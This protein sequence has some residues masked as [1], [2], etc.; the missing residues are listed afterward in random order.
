M[1]T[2]KRILSALALS[3]FLMSG[4]GGPEPEPVPGPTPVTPAKIS[5]TGVSLNKSSITLVEGANESLVATVSPS[6]ATDKEV[7]WSSSESS[8]ASVDSKGTVKA[9]KAGTTTVTV[10]TNDG[11]K[12]ASCSVTVE[13]KVISVT[14]VS[15]DQN[16]LE[17]IEG[18][19]AT[20]AS[21]VEPGD[22]TNKTVAW[23]SSDPTVAT[24]EDGKVVA[25]APG[26]A[27]ITVT[28]EDGK[29]TDS[30]EVTIKSKVIHLERLKMDCESLTLRAHWS[31]PIVVSFFPDNAEDQTVN[32]IS[33]D[34]S[35]AW[36]K[37]RPGQPYVCDVQAVSP[38][39]ASIIA[40]SNDGGKTA[41][42]NVTVTPIP[43]ERV[44]IS[45]SSML[46]YVG[47][48]IQW[49]VY[50]AP[51]EATNKNVTWKVADP[52][53]ASV[54]QNGVIKG[55][56]P[57]NTKVS[58]VSEDG[59][60]TSEHELWVREATVK[61]TSIELDK[62]T[63]SMTSGTDETLTA[64]L[65]PSDATNKDVIWFSSDLNV[66]WVSKDGIVS[67]K[68]PGTCTVTAISVDG[69]FESTCVVTVGASPSSKVSGVRMSNSEIALNVGGIAT[70]YATVSP[71]TATNKGLTWTSSDPS[72]AKVDNYGNV[73]AVKVGSAVITVKTAD[74]GYT[75]KCTV[76][77]QTQVV[78]AQK[79]TLD[80]TS[81]TLNVKSQ[82]RLRATISPSGVTNPNL[83]WESDNTSVA[84]V[85]DSGV[86]TAVGPGQTRIIVY[87]VDNGAAAICVVA[88]RKFVDSISISGPKSVSVFSSIHLEA[89]VSPANASNR[90]V[91]WSSSNTAI[92]TVDQ[93]GN[94]KGIKE[95][96]V[97]ISVASKDGSGAIATIQVTVTSAA[98]TYLMLA[99]SGAEVVNR[100][101]MIVGEYLSFGV[102]PYPGEHKPEVTW[103]CS[104]DDIIEIRDYMDKQ[105][106]RLLYAKKA[107]TCT[108]TL[109]AQDSGG[110]TRTFTVV[111]KQQ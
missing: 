90:N 98:T 77:V 49:D 29:K 53:I 107:G 57:G 6:D 92:A 59:G 17:L 95:G 99:D 55:L 79:V 84:R 25:V 48:E 33:T 26:T 31:E 2:I 64:I 54:D 40:V 22:A 32:W 67:A 7:S 21:T 14:S 63:L 28:T 96:E 39:E 52:S 9:V 86:V 80:R 42:C 82:L 11:G 8:V 47:Q 58:I 44:S 61:V 106:I 71:S 51:D 72:V 23:S 13:A 110:V 69:R 97:T 83:T 41:Q 111:V 87:S 91:S 74:G 16:S 60:F 46:V 50:Y 101:E 66:A 78:H 76:K 75:D 56:S 100:L 12:T 73:T 94:V 62:T 37:P 24:V 19:E 104:N 10:K 45:L 18:E 34:E 105:Y 27:T 102:V 30:C 70:L 3:L 108:I 4:C 1:L 68:N 88:V 89:S 38:G 5:V 20:L 36:P 43:L 65:N 109:K 15:I 81:V 103:T 93:S 85:D 35:V